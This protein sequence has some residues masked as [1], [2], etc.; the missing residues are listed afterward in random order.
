MRM[1]PPTSAVHPQH[2][3][4]EATVD[5]GGS[6]TGVAPLTFSWHTASAPPCAHGPTIIVALDAEKFS[7]YFFDC[8]I[9]WIHGRMFPIEILYTKIDRERRC[10]DHGIADPSN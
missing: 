9:F 4:E 6:A 8:N 10:T 2:A 1:G 3:T 5:V 7:F